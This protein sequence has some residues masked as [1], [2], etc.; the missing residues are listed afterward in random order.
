M[1]DVLLGQAYYL[2]LDPK[3]WRA[4]QPYPPLGTL[5]AAAY[6]REQ[7]PTVALFDAMLAE[8][9]DDWHT[10]LARARPRVAVIYED[11]FNYLSKMCLLRMRESA[12]AMVDAARAARCPVVVSGSDATDHPDLYLSRGASV[13]VLGEG[14]I[15]M[16][17]LAVRLLAGE[18]AVGVPG[19]AWCDAQGVVH[20]GPARPFIRSLDDL[21]R[22]AWDL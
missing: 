2:R 11:S 6:L 3:L 5:Y 16:A 20:R 18:P 12:L 8:T 21:P 15:T 22:P 4:Q 7:G 9:V 14:E 10:T 1:S 17:E 19:T 13:V